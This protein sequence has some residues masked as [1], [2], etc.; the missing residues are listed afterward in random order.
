MD[1][2]EHLYKIIFFYNLHL[3][4]KFLEKKSLESTEKKCFRESFKQFL[5]Q[6]MKS[7]ISL[8]DIPSGEEAEIVYPV[9]LPK[10][11][12][13]CVTFNMVAFHERTEEHLQSMREQIEIIVQYCCN[14]KEN[15]KE[16][17]NTRIKKRPKVL[18]LGLAD[19]KYRKQTEDNNFEKINEKITR[20]WKQFSFLSSSILVPAVN[21]L[22]FYPVSF[23]KPYLGMHFAASP[24]KKV[25]N[26]SKIHPIT[27]VISSYFES[28]DEKYMKLFHLFNPTDLTLCYHTWN[29]KLLEEGNNA[30]DSEDIT[31]YLESFNLLTWTNSFKSIGGEMIPINDSIVILRP[32]SFFRNLSDCLLKLNK[33]VK[34]NN[35]D[36]ELCQL[37]NDWNTE[38]DQ[39]QERRRFC[40]LGVVSKDI[41]F[42]LLTQE[43]VTERLNVDSEQLLIILKALGIITICNQEFKVPMN[44]NSTNVP[45]L[46]LKEVA[47]DG[48][49]ETCLF[50]SVCR[51]CCGSSSKDKRTDLVEN[52]KSKFEEKEDTEGNKG[53]ISFGSSCRPLCGSSSK[54][55]TEALVE[56]RNPKFEGEEKEDSEGNNGSILLGSS[57][58]PLCGSSSRAKKGVLI[59]NSDSKFEGEEKED[60]EGNKGRILFGSKKS[61][62]RSMFKRKKNS[63]AGIAT[64]NASQ[65]DGTT[66][67]AGQ[68]N[69]TLP[70]IDPLASGTSQ[71]E[72]VDNEIYSTAGSASDNTNQSED[73]ALAAGQNYQQQYLRKS[74]TFRSI[75]PL[76]PGT[77][78]NEEVDNEIYSTAG[79]ASDNTNQSEDTAL[80]AGQNYQ[81]QYLRKSKTFRS[82]V[83]LA[84]GTSQNGKV[85][86]EFYY[87]LPYL[88]ATRPSKFKA[89]KNIKNVFYIALIP[90][91]SA[92]SSEAKFS[93]QDMR[94]ISLVPCYF[95]QRL[96]A[97][98]EWYQ[99]VFR[100]S[101]KKQKNADSMNNNESTDFFS[102]SNDESTVVSMKSDNRTGFLSVG[103]DE[104]TVVSM[105]TDDSTNFFSMNND[106][107]IESTDVVSVDT[108]G[109]TD[110]F[111]VNTD[112]STDFVL[113]E[114]YGDSMRKQESSRVIKKPT[115]FQNTDDPISKHNFS[116]FS[117]RM[118]F[119]RHVTNTDVIWDEKFQLIQVT[120]DENS[121]SPLDSMRFVIHMMEDVI[122]EFHYGIKILPLVSFHSVEDEKLLLF[123]LEHLRKHFGD[124]FLSS[125]SVA[126]SSDNEVIEENISLPRLLLTLFS[127]PTNVK[128][129]KKNDVKNK[130]HQTY[131]FEKLKKNFYS[132]FQFYYETSLSRA[133]FHVSCPP[134]FT[135]SEDLQ[136]YFK[137]NLENTFQ[138]VYLK[139][140]DLYPKKEVF[141][142]S[143][144]P[145]KFSGSWVRSLMYSQHLLFIYQLE[146]FHT[147]M[148]ANDNMGGN[149][150]LTANLEVILY[151][152]IIIIVFMKYFY[153]ISHIK[154]FRV[155]LV[156]D[157]EVELRGKNF[158]HEFFAPDI[159]F[160]H[161]PFN[162]ITLQALKR[163]LKS[164]YQ[165][166]TTDYSLKH[167]LKDSCLTKLDNYFA[168][169][170]IPNL[171]V[172]FS[173]LISMN[174][175][176]FSIMNGEAPYEMDESVMR[177]FVHFIHSQNKR[178]RP[179]D[180]LQSILKN[181]LEKL[182]DLNCFAVERL[183]RVEKKPRF[184][185]CSRSYLRFE[186]KFED[187][188]EK[189]HLLF[190]WIGIILTVFVLAS[191]AAILESFYLFCLILLSL[192]PF[193]L[194][195]I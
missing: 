25:A 117:P 114:E 167:H 39:T 191:V 86:K 77:S 47:N 139:F 161:T 163:K 116:I 8:L 178:K 93:F 40:D 57:C 179:T 37:V 186:G 180:Q 19:D 122:N 120:Y 110:F 65:S 2:T 18:L 127:D 5:P 81:Q 30:A 162:Q 195:F 126:A 169:L 73:T 165:T 90:K 131:L 141:T 94:K 100:D 101:V 109:S 190:G 158:F 62:L 80:A 129:I 36:K 88:P 150:V 44:S 173:H 51:S 99:K 187:Y 157:K 28:F 63:N 177:N 124:H 149:V 6:E 130:H 7:C 170:T 35:D 49:V 134:T 193:I 92:P 188:L 12:I 82:I 108:N 97:K 10:F 136:N 9:M 34:P 154:S 83:P 155:I 194:F 189:Y 29:S 79:S 138:D 13:Y 14:R 31:N 133:I 176:S 174:Y 144:R 41:L 113:K 164:Y 172:E 160:L 4:K 183:F 107:N 26:S 148:T 56:N 145:D 119:H 84:P 60:S 76:A 87:F 67:V 115:P 33:P 121:C 74:K 166:M 147:L 66:P 96:T 72:E 89:M 112:K 58:R 70:S 11:A 85:D 123:P 46:K 21:N 95:M 151:E 17:D 152:W 38:L 105:N 137:S 153:E 52:G 142:C 184:V 32:F 98:A 20:L 78:Q 24:I 132:Y 16:D 3:D 91:E 64:D 171:L 45:L 102:V 15:F 27:N 175:H 104:S 55:K 182:I 156:L 43:I 159:K 168:S 192:S 128:H 135:I 61:W 54:A 146:D 118:G 185:I 103:S 181:Y 42:Y 53:R 125:N 68:N 69:E 48:N 106:E 59:E 143:K 22:F 111:S 50:G 1:S 140:C 75:V 23:S 71:N